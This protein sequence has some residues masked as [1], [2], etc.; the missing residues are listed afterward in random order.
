[1]KISTLFKFCLVYF[2]I[3]T[4]G[5]SVVAA[6]P[7][8]KNSV[9]LE[10]L[11]SGF[12]YSINYERMLLSDFGLRVGAEYAPLQSTWTAFDA[13]A[14][15][16]PV[17]INYL[18]LGFGAHRAEFGAGTSLTY[19]KGESLL[20]TKPGFEVFGLGTLGYRFQPTAGGVQFRVGANTFFGKDVAYKFESKNRNILVWPY[21][22]LGWAF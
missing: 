19:S 12:F 13:Y 4:S 17:T 22:S 10:G 2:L 1:M 16:F 20:S 3:T 11:G 15:S 9:F 21:L 6:H 5:Y 8:A 7:I 14:F 18:G